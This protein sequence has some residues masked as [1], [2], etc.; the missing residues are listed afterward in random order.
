M[1]VGAQKNC[2]MKMVLLSTDYICFGEEIGR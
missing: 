2:L 1:F